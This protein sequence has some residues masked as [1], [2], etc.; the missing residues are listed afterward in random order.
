MKNLL[1]NLVV[2]VFIIVLILLGLLCLKTKENF[3]QG[4][5]YGFS[6]YLS[7]YP[8]CKIGNNCF[9]GSYFN[10]GGYQNVCEPKEGLLKQKR[11]LIDN[12]VRIL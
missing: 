6:T 11:Q 1:L 12:R 10:R 9:R 4:Y 7:P 8:Q 3:I 2:I 5:G